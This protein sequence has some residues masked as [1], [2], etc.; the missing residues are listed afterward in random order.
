MSLA[1][2]LL[3][4]FGPLMTYADMATLFGCQGADPTSAM[5]QRMRRDKVLGQ[6]IRQSTLRLGRRVYFRSDLVAQALS[7]ASVWTSSQAAVSEHQRQAGEAN[8]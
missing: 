6:Q 4:R 3:A 1:E 8:L 7:T 5:R 2:I